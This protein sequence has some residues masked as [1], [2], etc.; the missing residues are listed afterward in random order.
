MPVASVDTALVKMKPLPFAAGNYQC[1]ECSD[2]ELISWNS[3]LEL[4]TKFAGVSDWAEKGYERSGDWEQ[5]CGA[6]LPYVRRRWCI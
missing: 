1:G 4:K 5:V 3:A 6:S 2:T